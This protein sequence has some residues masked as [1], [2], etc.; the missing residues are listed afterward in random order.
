M[1]S[2]F[3]ISPE[4]EACKGTFQSRVGYEEGTKGTSFKPMVEMITVIVCQAKWVGSVVP[5]SGGLI[6]VIY[7]P[8]EHLTSTLGQRVDLG[9]YR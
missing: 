9:I 2:Y 3:S 8:H 1:Y 6:A 4:R 5:F 7:L